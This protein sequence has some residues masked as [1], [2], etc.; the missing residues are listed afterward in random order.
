M[1]PKNTNET[2][3]NLMDEGRKVVNQANQRHIVVRKPDGT[4]ILELSATVFAIAVVLI[5]LFQPFG[6]IAAIAA[7][8]YAI[9]TKV[10]IEVVHELDGNEP[11]IEIN[12]TDEQ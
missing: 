4:K 5:F 7:L 8:I 3:N 10:K 2:I 1:K 6:T 11:T 9:Y 12:P